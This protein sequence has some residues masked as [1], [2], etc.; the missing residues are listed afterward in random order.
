MMFPDCRNDNHYNYDFLNAEDAAIVDGY[1]YC[2]ENAVDVAFDNIDA[3]P[4]E[5]LYVRPSDVVKVL[6]A[7]REWIASYIESERDELITSMIDSMD[8]AEFK[9]LREK[10]IAENGK[11]KYYDTRHYAIT[12]VKVFK[13]D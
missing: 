9:A 5:D 8:D 12:G 4:P 1:D 3:F 7:F 10:A 2:V 13:N 6:H 11:E